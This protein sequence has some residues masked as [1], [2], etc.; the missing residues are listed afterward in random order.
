M[1]SDVPLVKCSQGNTDGTR[2]Q[3]STLSIGTLTCRR[4]NRQRLPRAQWSLG[5]Y[6]LPINCCA[7]VYTSWALFWSLWP[8]QYPVTAAN[9]NWAPIIL[10]GTVI[11][12]ALLYHFD[13][14]KKY[15]APVIAEVEAAVEW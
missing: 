9:F 12:A 11:W 2:Y 13:R 8:S 15:E 5:R 14:G 10:I 4:L 3:T 1:T 7:L 6:G